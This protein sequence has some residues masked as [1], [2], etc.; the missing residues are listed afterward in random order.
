ML[1]LEVGYAGDDCRRNRTGDNGELRCDNRH[2][3]R[4]R[5]ADA[6]AAAD[7]GDDGQHR[8]GDVSCAGQY[9]KQIGYGGGDEGDVFRIAVQ[10]AGGDFNH[11][12]QTA[13]GLHRGG[14]G[15]D[16]HNHQHHV[17]RRAG[18]FEVEAEGQNRQADAAEHAQAD[19]ADLRANQDAQQYDGKLDKEHG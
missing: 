11:V 14:G 5:R 7:F 16:R 15:D 6:V 10:H 4:T 13:A 8:I 18:R 12:V 1:R 2:R 9:G 19:A 17:N 3:Q